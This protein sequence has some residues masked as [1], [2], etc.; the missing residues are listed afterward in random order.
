MKKIIILL[1]TLFLLMGCNETKYVPVENIE[2]NGTVEI[3]SAYIIGVDKGGFLIQQFD[4]D[5]KSYIIYK[6]CIIQSI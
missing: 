6:N 5:G 3:P 2:Q 4:Y 1:L